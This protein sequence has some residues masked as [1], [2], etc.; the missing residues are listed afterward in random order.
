MAAAALWR[1]LRSCCQLLD[2]DL[3]QPLQLGVIH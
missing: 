3:N 2:D 1:R